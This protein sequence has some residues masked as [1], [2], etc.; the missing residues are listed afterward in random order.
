MIFFVHRAWLRRVFL[1]VFF[2]L[3]LSAR[4]PVKA[5]W[6]DDLTI[7]YS[8]MAI[9]GSTLKVEAFE[10]SLYRHNIALTL[11]RGPATLGLLFQI[12][13]RGH[14]DDGVDFFYSKPEQGLMLTGGYDFLLSDRLRLESYGRLGLTRG[15]DFGQP[16]YATD[17]DLRVN[18]VVFDLDGAGLLR[19]KPYF[20]SGYVGVIVNRFGRI[21]GIAGAGVWWNGIGTYLT[22]FYAFNG[23]RDP[24]HPGDQADRAYARLQNA[25]VSLSL[26]YDLGPVMVGLKRN[27]P[28]LNGSNDLSFTLQFRHFFESGR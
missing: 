6:L 8:V 27:V 11:G 18:L 28:L 9:T 15:H 3:T 4:K 17:T 21:Q 23:V 22:G 26:S 25:G 13:D 14:V 10:P 16:L 24:L 2:L 12:T 7:R 19:G 1:P 20:R 5:Q